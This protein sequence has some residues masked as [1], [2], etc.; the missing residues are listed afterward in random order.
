MNRNKQKLLIMS[1]VIIVV[2]VMVIVAI[3]YRTPSNRPT[4]TQGDSPV[5]VN[6]DED[7]NTPIPTA[8]P[9]KP[10]VIL[11]YLIEMLDFQEED[12]Q[13]ISVEYKGMKQDIPAERLYVILQSLRWADTTAAKAETEAKA[14]VEQAVI[15]FALK[16]QVVDLPYDIN[17]NTFELGGSSYYADDQVL[18]LM[19]GLFRINVELAEL[20]T[21]LEQARIQQENAGNVDPEALTAERVQMDGL[22]FNGWETKLKD[23]ES[24]WTISFYDEGTGEVKKAQKFDHGIIML[25]RQI[26][27]TNDVYETGD[28]VKVGLT[29]D[30]VMD[31]LGPWAMKL[32]SRWS[33]KVGDYYN[34]HLYF[35][36]NKVK[37]IVLSQPL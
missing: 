15:H 7:N 11:P 28:G 19:Q 36:L 9:V 1:S 22:D 30:Q 20:D 31:K 34:F 10:I 26:I 29:I 24:V 16:E 32:V 3:T 14:D 25:N 5:E 18:L 17:N 6:K 2:V 35:D 21:F 8:T 33:Y 37:Y 13:S 23:A 27:F 12:V 4:S